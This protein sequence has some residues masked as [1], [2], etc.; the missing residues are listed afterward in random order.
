MNDSIEDVVAKQMTAAVTAAINPIADP[1]KPYR[2]NFCG[3]VHS[4]PYC[5]KL[6]TV[7]YHENGNL[8]SITF[9]VKGE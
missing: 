1:I 6:K 2:C 4:I 7:E 5:P 8:K 9:K 3:D